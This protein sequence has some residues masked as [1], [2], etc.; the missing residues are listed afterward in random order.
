[1]GF[2]RQEYWSGLP[3]PSS[4]DLSDPGIEPGSPALEADAL[5][6]EPPTKRVCVNIRCTFFVFSIVLNTSKSL[7]AIEAYPLEL[8]YSAQCL[9]T[10]QLFFNVFCFRWALGRFPVWNYSEVNCCEHCCVRLLVNI[11]LHYCWVVYTAVKLLAYGAYICSA[12]LDIPRQ[13]SKAMTVTYVP[14]RVS[15]SS[16]CFTSLPSLG[17]FSLSL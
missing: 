2:S 15:E 7:H 8:L 13:C 9:N 4:G 16:S 3:F 12:L 1:M 6:S 5:T 11:C 14:T 17:I 10:S